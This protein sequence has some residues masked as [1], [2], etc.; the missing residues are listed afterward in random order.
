MSE[1]SPAIDLAR[2]PK[3]TAEQPVV[4][5]ESIDTPEFRGGYYVLRAGATDPQ[6]PHLEHESYLVMAGRATFEIE[7]RRQPVRQGHAIVVPA[8]KEHRFV[9]IEEDLTLFVLFARRQSSA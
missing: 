9:D 2:A 6:H 1:R 3:A 8:F 5:E 7:G 4:Y